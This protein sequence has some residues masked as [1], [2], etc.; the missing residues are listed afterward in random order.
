MLNPISSEQ[1]LYF[2]DRGRQW[3]RDILHRQEPLWLEIPL[4]WPGSREQAE[5]IVQA[6]VAPSVG[7]RHRE[8]FVDLVQG[9]ARAVWRD[10]TNGTALSRTS[11]SSSVANAV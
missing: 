7:E 9:A 3:A 4:V 10:L 6:L 8:H 2:E 11:G 1:D 5:T